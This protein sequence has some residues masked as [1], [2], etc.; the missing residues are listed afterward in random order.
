[1]KLGFGN[2][3][4]GAEFTMNGNWNERFQKDSSWTANNGRGSKLVMEFEIVEVE[5][6]PRLNDFRGSVSELR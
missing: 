2:L 3:P 1:M 5:K 4:I 6:L